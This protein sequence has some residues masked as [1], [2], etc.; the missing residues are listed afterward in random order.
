MAVIT[1]SPFEDQKPGTSGLRKKVVVFEQKNYL[2]NFTQS[3]MS[4]FPA[5]EIQG[6]SLLVSGDGRYY[7]REAIQKICEVA[8]GNQ[9][10]RVLIGAHG[11]MSTP[12]ASCVIREKNLY[13]GILLTASH[14]PGGPKNDFGVKYNMSNGGPAPD[15]VTSRIFELSKTLTE[16]KRLELPPIDID[17]CGEVKLTE[18]FT[19]EVI[20]VVASWVSLMRSIFDFNAIQKLLNRPDFK[21][22]FDGMHGVAGPYAKAL[23]VDVFNCEPKS[24]MNCDPKPDFGGG[25]PDPNLT[26]AEELVKIMK[27][28]AP[29][30][31]TEDTPDFGAAADGDCDRNMV[32]GKGF[33]VTPSDSVAII[34]AY[35]QKCIPY[36]AGGLSGV[37]RSMPTSCAIDRVAAKLGLECFET[38]TGWKYFGNLM[39]AGRM[40]ICGEESF[41]TGSDHVREKDGIWAVLAWLSILAHANDENNQA[42]VSVEAIVTGFWQEYGRCY[43]SRYDYEE[44]E[45]T[46]ANEVIDHLRTLACSD[47]TRLHEHVTSEEAKTYLQLNQVVTADDFTYTDPVDK[48]VAANQGVRYIFKDGSRMIWRLSGT[49]SVGATVR[50]YFEKYEKDDTAQPTAAA[51]KVIIDIALELCKIHEITGRAGPTVVT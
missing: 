44:V 45:S 31:V 39:D 13:G 47:L 1:T 26:Y 6:C 12:A 36:F 11:L 50:V 42:L 38:P 46:K 4:C 21:L 14:N 7:S 49:G 16:Y 27:P 40:A 18:T 5:E 23:F 34:A 17:T 33:F 48:S 19:V 32:L 41:G 3:I 43:Y 22:I 30:E 51:L 24:C 25:H 15:A 10:G 2:E 9:V 8:A 29:Q 20:D 35:A 28:L 37:A